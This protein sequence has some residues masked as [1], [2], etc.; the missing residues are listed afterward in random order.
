MSIKQ[1]SSDQ[2]LSDLSNNPVFSTIDPSK[3]FGQMQQ[4]IAHCKTV[5]DESV[6]S[7]EVSFVNVV[8]KLEEADDAL[9]NLFSPISHM[10]SVVSSDELREAHDACLPLLSEYSTFVGQHQGL[11]DLYKALAQSQAFEILSVA[12]QKVVTNAVR[13]FELS[14]VALPEDKKKEYAKISARLSDLASQ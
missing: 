2:A 5:I 7:G 14:G 1:I 12:Q 8:T 11:C 13:D 3:V 10:N 9:S 4:A 6:N